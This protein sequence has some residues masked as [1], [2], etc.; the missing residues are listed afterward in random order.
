MSVTS[1]IAVRYLKVNRENLFFSW[2]AILSILGV[3]IGVA[4]MIVVLSVISGFEY[5]LRKRFLA[6]NAHILTYR[7][8]SGLIQPDEWAKTIKEDFD[9]DVKGISSFI[10]YET[11]AREGSLLQSILIRGIVPHDRE[12]VQSLKSIVEPISSLKVLQD[13]ID[14]RKKGK[15][16]PELPGIIVG[17]GLLS[18]LD[19]KVGGQIQLVSPIKKG[20]QELTEFSIVGVYDSGLKHYDNRIA[21]LSLTTAQDFFGMGERVTG[22]EIGLNDPDDS[23][24]VASKMDEK[25]SLSIREWQTFNRPLFEAMQMEKVVIGTIVA[26]VA[27]VAS[28]N[29]L[30]TLFVSVSQKQRD[31]S[32][33]KA[34]G[35]NNRQILTLFLKQGLAIGAIGGALGT[36]LALGISEVLKRFKII[37][38]PDP[39]LLARLPITYE[40]E[41]FLGVVMA[42]MGLCLVAG[43]YPALMATRVNPTEGFKG[44]AGNI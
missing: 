44:T 1:Y 15:P 4:A 5:E 6:A 41:I 31:I 25:Y 42:S 11:M 20:F 2:I 7:F 34:L 29:I 36:V 33:L 8:P 24:R 43:L 40:W 38:L 32:I 23:Q 39:Y 16:V 37:D 22:L 21:F 3:A 12:K 27:L 9:D 30:T 10:H 28:L 18:I 14:A 26:L 17:K 35:A 13:E 19:L